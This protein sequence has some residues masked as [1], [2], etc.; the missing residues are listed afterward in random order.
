MK[1]SI[2]KLI[3]AAL[4]AVN[5]ATAIHSHVRRDGDKL[6][7]LDRVYDLVVGVASLKENRST[8]QRKEIY[9]LAL[10]KAAVPMA[11]AIAQ[12]LG[13]DIS[14]GLVVTKSDHIGAATFPAGWE[15][16]EA[17]HPTPDE[18][19]LHAG[20]RV[21]DFLGNCTDR[22]LIIAC[23]S[24]GASALVVAPRT[25]SSIQQ[26]L[27][28]PPG[29]E[30]IPSPQSLINSALNSQAIDISTVDPDLVI[31]LTIMQAINTELLGS[32]LN[33]EQINAVRA[34]LDRLKGG[35]LVNRA[36]PGRVIGLILSDVIGEAIESIASGLTHHPKAAN[37]IVASNSQACKAVA[38][39][40]RLLGYDPTIV[41]TEWDGDAQERGREIAREIVTR[42]PKTVLIYG[43]ETTVV[44]PQDAQGKGGRNQEL[45]L[46]AAIELDELATPAWVI[47]LATDGT[48]GPTDAAGAT[49]NEQTIARALD[50]GLDAKSALDRHDSYPFFDRLGDLC[51]IG[52]TGT[53]V[54]DIT[55][56]IRP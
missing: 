18:R 40:A 53:N 17:G 45:A 39:T 44:L 21:W 38:E 7:I 43:G 26:L 34:K 54:A 24:G 1:E 42:A 27:L 12:I 55:I 10:G 47:T 14:R 16:I 20:D 32:G 35:G 23:I 31:P 50:L 52:A 2:A 30:T 22:T 13:S 28:A 51:K 56:A 3:A 5:P 41:T 25:W 49:V 15:V 33:I 46:A 36:L 4:D 8:Q 48:D 19:S 9:C 37:T 29:S 11:Q 6:T